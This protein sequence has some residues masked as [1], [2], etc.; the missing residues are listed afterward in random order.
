MRFH[1][2]QT[3]REVA[4]QHPEAIP[5]FEALGIDYC[6]GGSKTLG[7]SCQAKQLEWTKL[8]K[9]LEAAEAPAAGSGT[10]WALEPLNALTWHIIDAHHRYVRS[11]TLRIRH[12][13]EKVVAKH[14]A[15][16][17]EVLEVD[18]VFN[19]LAAELAM[20]MMKEE[21]ILF[22]YIDSLARVDLDRCNP[23]EPRFGTVANPIQQM[24]AEHD[25]AGGNMARIHAFTGGYQPPADAC[26]TF[27]GLYHGLAEFERD[28]HQHVHLENNILFP[29]ALDVERRLLSVAR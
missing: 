14:G 6:C 29:R 5:V 17:P 13:L 19:T 12:W 16:H 18:A 28:L 4:I 21:Q 22:P 9:L 2:E 24:M 8:L 1:P 11:A 15:T 26:P 3:T 27:R 10:D 25:D 7:E 23:V 20:H